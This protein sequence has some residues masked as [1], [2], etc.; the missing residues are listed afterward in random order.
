MAKTAN[1]EQ[2][3]ALV[4]GA[5]TGLGFATAKMLS[6]NGWQVFGTI[7]PSQSPDEL[8]ELGITPIVMD[9]TDRESVVDGYEFIVDNVG[10]KGLAALVN[11]AGVAGIAGGVIEGVSEERIKALFDVNVFGTIR[12]I[13]VFLPLLRTFGPARIVN[14]SSSGVRVPS[15]F[16][17]IYAISKYAVEGITNSLRYEMPIFGIQVTSIEP[18][19]M[20]T[21]MTANSK[22]NMAKTWGMMPEA[23][24]ELYYEKLNPS[25][26]Y[27]D[28]MIQQANPP[29]VV[30]EVIL[31]ALN[32]KNMRI[33]YVGGKDVRLMPF[34]QRLLGE[35]LF[36]KLMITV[37]KLPKPDW[38]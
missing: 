15:A 6:E 37:Q 10:D 32:A 33:R 16:S 23:V 31:K 12:V 29:E 20:D 35:N 22:E 7:I 21:P 19:A 30:A 14:V 13:Q 17:G 2:K 36:E 11:V 9:I 34:L 28:N 18:G 26:E 25:L 38:A 1:T 8:K 4:T 24:R 27:M 3:A 5:G